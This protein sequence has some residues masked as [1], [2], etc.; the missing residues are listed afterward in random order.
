VDRRVASVYGAQASA[1]SPK[2]LCVASV[3]RQFVEQGPGG[4]PTL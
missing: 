1:A 2:E 4:L 3:Q